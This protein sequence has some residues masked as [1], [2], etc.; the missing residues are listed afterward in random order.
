[1]SYKF[2]VAWAHGVPSQ[3]FCQTNRRPPET[4][5]SPQLLPMG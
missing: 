2:L 1:L 3:L 4:A 5:K